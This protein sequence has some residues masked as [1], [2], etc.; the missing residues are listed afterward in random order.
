MEY[1]GVT[2]PSG[3]FR[4]PGKQ[5]VYLTVTTHLAE[6]YRNAGTIGLPIGILE[7]QE[8]GV[9]LAHLQLEEYPGS[10]RKS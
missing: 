6:R 4:I 9:S 3:A 5:Q 7:N 2:D 8:R 10:C 1:L